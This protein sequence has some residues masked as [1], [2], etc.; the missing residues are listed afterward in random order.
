MSVDNANPEQPFPDRLSCSNSA[1]KKGKVGDSN[2]Q[3]DD[4]A[5]LVEFDEL[6]EK[7]RAND[8]SDGAK[9]QSIDRSG[10]DTAP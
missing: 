4:S 2:Q 6:G 8:H 10:A 7:N 3:T 5:Q 9:D 1:V